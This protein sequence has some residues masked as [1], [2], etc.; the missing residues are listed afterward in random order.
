MWVALSNTLLIGLTL[1]LFYP[2]ARVRM[3]R[4]LVGSLYVT[5]EG[6]DDIRAAEVDAS[7][8]LGDELGDAFD[9]GVGI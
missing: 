4:L 8:A 9:I 3:Q 1:G 7:S 6:L 2:W 5:G